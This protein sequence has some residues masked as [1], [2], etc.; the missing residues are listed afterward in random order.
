MQVPKEFG[1]VLIGELSNKVLKKCFWAS[2]AFMVRVRFVRMGRQKLADGVELII[3]SLLEAKPG[4]D[5]EPADK[6]SDVSSP[7]RLAVGSIEHLRN[8][9]V[10]PLEF[11]YILLV[12]AGQYDIVWREPLAKGERFVARV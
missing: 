12:H 7:S 2:G 11:G 10:Q 8:G 6:R 1:L 3:N 5:H 4:P 9:Q